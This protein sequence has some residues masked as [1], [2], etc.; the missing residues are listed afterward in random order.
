MGIISIE[1]LILSDFLH[2]YSE[3]WPSYAKLK[4]VI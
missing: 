1:K 2:K 3:A 4:R